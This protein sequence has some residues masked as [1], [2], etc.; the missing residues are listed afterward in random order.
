MYA[1]QKV[2]R[3]FDCSTMLFTLYKLD[4]MVVCIN[5]HEWPL[6][7]S[8]KSDVMT[9]VFLYIIMEIAKQNIIQIKRNTMRIVL[10]DVCSKILLPDTNV[11]ITYIQYHKLPC[12]VAWE[13]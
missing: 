13:F 6:I 5:A 2:L 3:T 10:E 9:K 4:N 12:W 8:A 1:H 7:I 11:R